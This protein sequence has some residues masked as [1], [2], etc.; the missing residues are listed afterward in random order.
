[1]SIKTTRLV[2]WISS[3]RKDFKGFPAG[4]QE[5][6]LSVLTIA[7]E[8]RKADIAKPMKGLGSGVFEVALPYRGNA[9][10]VVYAV[11]IGDEI[12]VIHAFQKKSATGIKTQK[13]EID[14]VKDRLKRLKE[15]LK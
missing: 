14:L 3:A 2:S 8:G 15:M 9:F 4:A 7:A 10:R 13:H 5:I 11:Q 1:M 6:I 12:W